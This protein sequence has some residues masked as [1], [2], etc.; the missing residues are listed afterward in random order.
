M[1]VEKIRNLLFITVFFGLLVFVNVLMFFGPKEAE[2]DFEYRELSTFPSLTL[3]SLYD[4]SFQTDFETAYADQ[5]YGRGFLVKWQTRMDYFLTKYVSYFNET[6]NKFIPV[7]QVSKYNEHYV[8]SPIYYSESSNELV[9][10]HANMYNEI[11]DTIDQPLFIYKNLLLNE[12]DWLEGVGYQ[13]GP[14]KYKETFTS[15]LNDE[16][17]FKEMQ[18]NNYDEYYQYYY[19]TDLHN[20]AD[21]AYVAYSDLIEMMNDVFPQIGEPRE[22]TQ[23]VCFQDVNYRG[24]YARRTGMYSRA[25]DQ[26]CDLFVEGAPSFTTYIDGEQKE[27]GDRY[28]YHNG[29]GPGYKDIYHYDAFYGG[30]AAEIKYDYG[31]NTGLNALFLVDSFSNPMNGWF[32]SHFDKTYIIDLRLNHEFVLTEFLEEHDIDVVAVYLYYDR[33]YFSDQYLI[34]LE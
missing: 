26:I 22:V 17:Y 34:D 16:I 6:K 9:K 24:S 25:T 1:R 27:N 33:L 28:A 11:D 13:E 5:F 3:Q 14:Q 30:Y 18:I 15:I 31:K 10:Q 7:R 19:K 23:K 32:A 8:E 20:T 2:A 21:G 12:V 4:R 29:Y